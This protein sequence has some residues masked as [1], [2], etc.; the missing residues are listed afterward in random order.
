M[1]HFE[2]VLAI[3]GNTLREAI[4]N[5]ALY[6]LLFFAIMLIGAGIIL[7]GLSYSDN[8]RIFQT[9]GLAAIR[10][11]STATAIFL[12]VGLIYKEIERR[13]IYTIVSKPIERSALVSAVR[14]LVQYPIPPGLP[15][16]DVAATARLID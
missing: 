12:G 2:R 1:I 13:T 11:F 15:R 8:D 3:A 16:V 10:I 14:R 9:I 6:G 7:G 4:R 5:R